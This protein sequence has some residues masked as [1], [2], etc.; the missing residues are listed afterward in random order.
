F[1]EI[2]KKEQCRLVVSK[3]RLLHGIVII[4]SINQ[5]EDESL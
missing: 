2:N 3:P 1:E 5:C 4:E